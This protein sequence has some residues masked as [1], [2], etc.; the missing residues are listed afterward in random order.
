[1][2]SKQRAKSASTT[3]EGKPGKLSLSKQVL[4]DLTPTKTKLDEIRGA[5]VPRS[6]INAGCD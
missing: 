6:R 1:M 2:T 3:R 5:G 4:K